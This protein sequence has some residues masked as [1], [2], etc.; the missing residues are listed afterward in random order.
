MTSSF[1][2]RVA[3]PVIVPTDCWY[4][5]ARSADLEHALTSVRAVG[6]P[7]VLFRSS[8]GV[9]V[10]LEDRCAHRAYP[11]SAGTL[12]GDT[13]RCGLSG[14]VYDAGGQCISVPTQARVPLG[15]FVE[16]FP[17]RESDGLVWVWFGESGRARLHRLPELPWLAD[18]AW[19]TV[20]GHRTVDASF[21]LLHENFADVTQVPFV[22]PEISPAVL[23]SAPPPL[24]VT[25][26]ETTVSLRREFPPAR[27]PSWQSRLAGVPA[28]AEFSTV[29]EGYLLSPA[30]WVD[31]WDVRTSDTTWARLRFTQAVT[32]IDERSSHLTWAVSR[33]FAV[34]D[35]AATLELT[36]TFE[37]YYNRVL[38]AMETAQSVIDRDGPGREVNVSADIVGLRIREIVEALVAEEGA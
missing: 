28:D 16:S 12:D 11:L 31:Y 8:Q 36:V 10:A 13:I 6:R 37:D 9:A 22:A 32:P 26:S 2:G 23:G 27:M 15:A 18:P 29:Q 1:Q 5:V 21:L 25:V 14:F 30:V 38:M 24:E 20:G 3:S 35:S 19:A 33:D 34:H 4:A 7:V 17:V